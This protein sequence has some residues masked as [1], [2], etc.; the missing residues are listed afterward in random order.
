MIEYDDF[1][2]KFMLPL[3]KEQHERL[4]EDDYYISRKIGKIL[5]YEIM[6]F[7]CFVFRYVR[8]HENYSRT[9]EKHQKG[10]QAKTISKED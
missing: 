8:Y 9:E 5:N 4:S 10:N 6:Y 3:S 2:F 1:R 7:E